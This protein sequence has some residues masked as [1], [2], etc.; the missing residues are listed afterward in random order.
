MD[1]ELEWA[2]TH[3]EREFWRRNVQAA[4]QTRDLAKKGSEARQ[5]AY[6]ARTVAKARERLDYSRSR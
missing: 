1:E 2:D 4:I 3:E 5:L 6:T